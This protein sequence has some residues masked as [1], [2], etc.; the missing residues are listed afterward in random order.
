MIKKNHVYCLSRLDSKDLYNLQITLKFTKIT[1]QYYYETLFNQTDIDWKIPRIVTTDTKLRN[2][3]YKILNNVL[4]LNKMLL[5]FGI[6][7]DPS[8]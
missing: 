6:S 1:S 2:F 3:Q 7:K 4:Y 8:C 5:K